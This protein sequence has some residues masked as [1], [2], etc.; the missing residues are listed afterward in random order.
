MVSLAASE[1]RRIKKSVSLRPDQYEAVIKIAKA[2]RHGNVSLVIQRL[3]DQ[4]TEKA[5]R[6]AREVSAA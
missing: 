4:E 6:E 1:E 5:E 2:E 3:I